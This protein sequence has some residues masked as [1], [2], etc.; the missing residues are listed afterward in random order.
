[1]RRYLA[2]AL[3]AALVI[4]VA[5]ACTRCASETGE[6]NPPVRGLVPCN[7]DAGSSDPEACPPLDAG[8][9]GPVSRL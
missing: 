7:P 5:L 4:V 9:D 3:R 1:M 8:V 2:M 6:P